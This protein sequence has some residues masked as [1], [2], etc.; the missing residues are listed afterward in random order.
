MGH[1]MQVFSQ[2]QQSDVFAAGAAVVKSAAI[3][4]PAL[5]DGSPRKRL[6]RQN[7]KRSQSITATALRSD[8]LGLRGMRNRRGGS[9]KITVRPSS[10]PEAMRVTVVRAD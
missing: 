5:Q 2:L 3:S 4:G 6:E 1:S 8:C 7:R 10:C 9:M